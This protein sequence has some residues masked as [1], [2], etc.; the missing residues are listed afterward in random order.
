METIYEG[1][2][3]EEK[4]ELLR[5]NCKSKEI[6]KVK[7]FFSQDDLDEMKSRLSESSIER[8]AVEDELSEISKGLRG[9]IKSHTKEINNLLRLLKNKYE[10]ENQEVF[11]FDDQENGL[12]LT[13]N[14]DGELV[15]S[16][17]LRPDERQT[18]IINMN[19][20]TA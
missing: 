17:K 8:K 19:Q 7:V 15:S 16:R 12:M 11:Y 1:K 20:K 13:Y 6:E 5:A 9:Q 2:S 3:P 4:I 10:Y 18:S 14:I